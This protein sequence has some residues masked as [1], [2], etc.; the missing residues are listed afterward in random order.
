M[1]MPPPGLWWHLV[2]LLLKTR[3]VSVADQNVVVSQ[4]G[5][6]YVRVCSATETLSV[7]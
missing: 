1:G 4:L 5:Y 2:G 6:L 3:C 7:I